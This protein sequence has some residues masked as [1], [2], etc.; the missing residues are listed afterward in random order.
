[1]AGHGRGAGV[2]GSRDAVL[3]HVPESGSRL[4]LGTLRRASAFTGRRHRQWPGIRLVAGPITLRNCSSAGQLS[5]RSPLSQGQA[6]VISVR[7]ELPGPDSLSS[8]NL[9][10]IITAVP[11]V[12]VKQADS[13][14]ETVKT[15][16]S[17]L[18]PWYATRPTPSKLSLN[19]LADPFQSSEARLYTFSQE[20]K[21]HLRKFRLGTSRANEPQAVICMY[22]SS[23]TH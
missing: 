1:M 4:Q 13:S 23:L 16:Q 18:S 7:R 14:P 15:V 10:A 21:D 3:I 20:T 12:H 22:V 9:R 2:E 19:D 6:A 17:T 5:Q 8:R 11:M